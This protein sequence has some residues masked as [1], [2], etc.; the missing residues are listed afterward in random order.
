M[1]KNKE[2]IVQ[3]LTINVNKINKTE[4]ISLT[5]FKVYF[6]KEWIQL[7]TEQYNQKNLGF[8]VKRITDSIDEVRNWLDT[9]PRQEPNRSRQ[10][11]IDDK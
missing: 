6:Y 8:H 7:K 3:G 9:F 10:K 5:E 11:Y 4:Y 1:A 2:L